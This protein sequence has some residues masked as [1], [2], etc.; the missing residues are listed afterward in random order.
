[1]RTDGRQDWRHRS[2][3]RLARRCVGRCWGGPGLEH[4]QRPGGRFGDRLR[5]PWRASPEGHSRRMAR[6][7]GRRRLRSANKRKILYTRSFPSALLDVESQ[8][9]GDLLAAI[10]QDACL[11]LADSWDRVD[12]MPANFESGRL[13]PCNDPDGYLSINA[14]FKNRN[15]FLN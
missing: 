1:M 10:P 11:S 6:V 12:L 15:C 3:H 4:G 7:P 14:T 13:E 2:A 9:A 5:G 8:V